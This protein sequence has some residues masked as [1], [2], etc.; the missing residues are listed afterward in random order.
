METSDKEDEK[1][2]VTLSI[3]QGVIQLS[4]LQIRNIFAAHGAKTPANDEVI[5]PAYLAR[6]IFADVLEKLTFLRPEHRSLLL[7]EADDLIST[8]PEAEQLHT[9]IF[10]DAKYVVWTGYT[11]FLD[12]ENGENVVELP[13]PPQETIS[14]NLNEI[15]R[16]FILKLEKR[17]GLYVKRQ[18]A[19]GNVE[20]SSDLRD[21][22]DH[23]LS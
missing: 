3:V 20:E 5:L 21:R 2:T 9:L 15:Y 10:A 19:D 1:L 16:R 23:G 4:K 12:L 7:A 11:G 17:S 6:L 13:S 14:Y 22:T 8:T 18:N